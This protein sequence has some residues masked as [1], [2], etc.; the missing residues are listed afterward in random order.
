MVIVVVLLAE[1]TV[2][3]SGAEKG[4]SCGYCVSGKQKTNTKF[5]EAA[6]TI[7]YRKLNSINAEERHKQANRGSTKDS[8]V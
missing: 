1:S 6:M 2:E 8:D 4:L 7:S 3:R 5:A